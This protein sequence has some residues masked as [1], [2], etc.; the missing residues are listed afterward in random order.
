MEEPFLVAGTTGQS[1]FFSIQS[2]QLAFQFFHQDGIDMNPLL[3]HELVQNRFRGSGMLFCQLQLAGCRN[4]DLHLRRHFAY[5]FEEQSLLLL[6]IFLGFLEL[7]DATAEHQPGVFQIVSYFIFIRK[8]HRIM[9]T[10]QTGFFFR[11]FF[12]V[13]FPALHK[14]SH[15]IVTKAGRP[16]L[17]VQLF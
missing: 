11:Q 10:F 14:E 1:I 5:L 8:H 4:I 17:L 7:R 16:F 12:P 13:V 15:E 9:H 6:Q 2:A 3:L